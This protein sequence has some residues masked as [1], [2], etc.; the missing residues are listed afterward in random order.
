MCFGGCIFSE[1]IFHYQKEKKILR[2]LSGVF[3]VFVFWLQSGFFFAI[4]LPS[5]N[6]PL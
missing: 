2:V 6:F 4:L 3:F 1:S 5:Q